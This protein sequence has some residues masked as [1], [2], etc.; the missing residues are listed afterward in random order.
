MFAM[1]I[2]TAT[3]E[4]VA[5]VCTPRCFENL[6]GRKPVYDRYSNGEKLAGKKDSKRGSD[7]AVM[8]SQQ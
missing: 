7:A 3:Q 6:K 8:T 1:I 2:C 5:F 4:R